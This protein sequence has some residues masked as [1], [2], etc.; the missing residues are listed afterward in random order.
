MTKNIYKILID[1]DLNPFLLFNSN[2]KLIDFNA[3]AEFL[4]NLVSYKELF[5]LALTYA[6][7]SYGINKKYLQLSYNKSRY[8]AI[9]VS[10]INDDE[11]ALRL[12]KVVCSQKEEFVLKDNVK[13]VNI[14][15][16]IELSKN[17][18]F[19]QQ[20]INIKEI[21]DISIPELK[22]NI[23]NF[24]VI[25]NECF[26]LYLKEKELTI[27]V[28]IKTGEYEVIN[29]IKYKILCI[30]F[31]SKKRDIE[32]SSKLKQNA[33]KSKINTFFENNTLKLELTIMV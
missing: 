1:N 19:I 16:L 7:K 27:K 12:F 22:I 32:V 2:G 30:E 20:K 13:S 9:S 10:Y 6:S 18:T 14:Y 33:T 25:L 31:L 29:N 8:Y 28:S 26:G 5:D 15:S 23:N 24:L 11:I 4:L 21:Y 17:T 3:E